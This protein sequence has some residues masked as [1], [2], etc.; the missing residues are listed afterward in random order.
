VDALGF[1]FDGS[2]EWE[3]ASVIRDEG[4]AFR[5]KIQV[6]EDGTFDVSCS[7]TELLPKGSI[8]TFDLFADA[9]KWCN[10]REYELVHPERA[11]A[12][13]CIDPQDV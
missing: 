4:V 1:E 13:T 12:Y 11:E 2:G 5:W 6:C 9:E 7:D 10:R 8:G 3:A